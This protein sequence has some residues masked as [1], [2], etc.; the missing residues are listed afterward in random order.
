[1]DSGTINPA[2]LNASG[3]SC[4][5]LAASDALAS[6]VLSIASIHLATCANTYLQPRLSLRTCFHSLV[7]VAPN[8]PGRQTTTP[9]QSVQ[10]DTVVRI[11]FRLGQR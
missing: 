3:M 9:A 6:F 7:R 1:M 8:E 10:E 11:I 4:C 2:A 5:P